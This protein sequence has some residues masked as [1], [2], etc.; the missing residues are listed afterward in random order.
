MIRVLR[1]T[2]ERLWFDYP[3][4]F[5]RADRHID[6]PELKRFL[7][8]IP[9]L[10]YYDIPWASEDIADYFVALDE[11]A[12]AAILKQTFDIYWAAHN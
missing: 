10:P 7:Q 6:V 2:S 4:R 3:E 9:R 1:D 11:P 5:R 8:S 12:K